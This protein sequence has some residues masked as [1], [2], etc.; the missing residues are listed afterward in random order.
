MCPAGVQLTHVVK[1][2]PVSHGNT[3]NITSDVHFFPRAFVFYG[4]GGITNDLKMQ[5]Y[6]SFFYIVPLKVIH[7]YMTSLT[8][9]YYTLYL[10]IK[11]FTTVIFPQWYTWLCC[12]PNLYKETS[13]N[14]YF[15]WKVCDWKRI[16]FI[17]CLTAYKNET[18]KKWKKVSSSCP[19]SSVVVP[20][21]T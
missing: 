6:L 11:M 4:K 19:I 13:A 18:S 8:T 17:L 20:T 10:V 14:R 21:L 7:T 12:R 1:S 16:L 9:K 5:L 2:F 15:T 3:R